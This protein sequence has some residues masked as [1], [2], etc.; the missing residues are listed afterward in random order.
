MNLTTATSEALLTLS[1][2]AVARN[3]VPHNCCVFRSLALAVERSA[4]ASQAG[5]LVP[6]LASTLPRRSDSSYEP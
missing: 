6:S 5:G 2:H 4:Y 1:D 3:T